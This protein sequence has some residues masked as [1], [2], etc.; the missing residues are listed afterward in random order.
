LL[1]A[2]V[3]YATFKSRIIHHRYS[4]HQ[5][6]LEIIDAESAAVIAAL[7]SFQ[8]LASSR[9]IASFA[10]ARVSQYWRK[11]GTIA[12]EPNIRKA[13]AARRNL[14]LNGISNCEVVNA[15]VAKV[16]VA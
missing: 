9:N 14:Q 12:I 3:S 7:T 5:L 4:A 11:P 6:T 15:A 8:T 13:N 10:G 16:P 2:K 1:W